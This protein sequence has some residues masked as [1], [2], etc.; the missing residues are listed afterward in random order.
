MKRVRLWWSVGSGSG[1]LL[2]RCYDHRF[3]SLASFSAGAV[4]I[5]SDC[6]ARSLPGLHERAH[7]LVSCRASPSGLHGA[8]PHS[9]HCRALMP[10]LHSDGFP[11]GLV[12]ELAPLGSH[13]G[14]SLAGSG[15]GFTTEPASLGS[16]ADPHPDGLP[17]GV[18]HRARATGLSGRTFPARRSAG[19]YHRGHSGR[20]L[21]FGSPPGFT[22]ERTISLGRRAS[23]RRATPRR[24]PV[25]G[26]LRLSPSACYRQ[27]SPWACRRSV[28][29]GRSSADRSL[30]ALPRA[31][32]AGGSPPT[33]PVKRS[34]IRHRGGRCSRPSA[35]VITI[36]TSGWSWPSAVAI[37]P[38]AL[39]H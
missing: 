33:V 22:S 37:G 31:V 23:T 20:I 39:G 18:H 9:P 6:L 35:P 11:L 32:T 8:S 34:A 25:T 15:L 14:S 17:L 19:L 38:S 26:T 29:A 13:R 30:T 28:A 4:T 12:T 27:P 1:V 24:P 7:P 21:L 5:A 2:G 3:S 10:V 16:H 36:S